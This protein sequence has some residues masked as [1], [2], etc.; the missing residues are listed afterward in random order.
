MNESSFLG[1]ANAKTLTKNGTLLLCWRFLNSV[2][3][4]YMNVVPLIY[5][6]EIGKSPEIVAAIYSFGTLSFTIGLIPFGMLAD[7]YGRKKFTVIGGAIPALAYA[8]FGFTTNSSWLIFASILGG[9]GFAGGIATSM[10]SPA[11]LALLADSTSEKNRT[12]LFALMQGITTAA[13][14]LGS[15]LSF[16]PS[17]IG[18]ELKIGL[19]EAHS[20]AF[21]IM[22]GLAIASIVPLLIVSETYNP[23]EIERK[24]N[25]PPNSR[26]RSLHFAIGRNAIQ[27]SVVFGLAGLGLGVIIQLIP[28]WLNLTYGVSEATAGAWIAISNL[29]SIGAIVLIPYW[30]RKRGTVITAAETLGLSSAFLFL[31][32]FPNAFELSAILY[33]A[34]TFF[35][36]I[37][38]T[39]IQSYLLGVTASRERASFYGLTNTIWGVTSSTGTILGGFLLSRNLLSIPL[40]I[41][42][43]AY[44]IAAAMFFLF[45]KGRRPP[46]ELP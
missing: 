36:T 41:G 46:E 10:S 39:V 1:N 16:V 6:L 32:P 40:F 33:V 8:I 7:R 42:A 18:G 14:S 20:L 38:W 2:P 25:W 35:V 15:V 29:I 17:S 9:I 34:R 43:T 13:Y 3:I 26:T 27:F 45:F 23:K 19:A 31:M 28:T 44:S 11:F 37:A 4:G 21:F 5:L 24:E 30:V 22:S 12:T